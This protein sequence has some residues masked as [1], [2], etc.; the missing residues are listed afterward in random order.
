MRH[1][2]SHEHCLRT[3][4][5]FWSVHDRRRFRQAVP[6]ENTVVK[7]WGGNV[8]QVDFGTRSQDSRAED[9]C[10]SSTNC[11]TRRSRC[12]CFEGG[13]DLFPVVCRPSFV[14]IATV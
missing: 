10:V 1:Y 13:L 9:R 12:S 2:N 14:Y 7:R 6:V 4:F 3:A 5:A 11:A 8:E